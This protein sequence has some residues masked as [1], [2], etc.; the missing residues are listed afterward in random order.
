M[1]VSRLSRA[2]PHPQ[3]CRCSYRRADWWV[4]KPKLPRRLL[5]LD[6]AGQDKSDNSQQRARRRLIHTP[7]YQRRTPAPPP[8]ARPIIHHVCHAEVIHQAPTATSRSPCSTCRRSGGRHGGGVVPQ[9]AGPPAHASDGAI[10]A[11]GWP[12]TTTSPASPA[13]RRGGHRPRRRR[14][15][16]ASASGRAASCCP[17][18]PRS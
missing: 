5:R 14:D 18:T 17:T 15:L 1:R 7:S 3:L 8:A 13:R 9:H 12:S 4:I 6:G 2:S 11:T 16:D 10:S